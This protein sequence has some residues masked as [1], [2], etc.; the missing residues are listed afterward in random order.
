MGEKP[1]PIALSMSQDHSKL[2]E[3]LEKALKTREGIL[4]APFWAFREGLLRHIGIEETILLPS[5][6]NPSDEVKSLAQ[7]LRLEHGALTNLLVPEPTREI[8][9]ALQIILAP[10]NV[11]E[12]S[13]GGF[14]SFVDALPDTR[15]KD[16][17]RRIS[18]APYPP[19]R[20]YSKRPQALEAAKR[21]MQRAGYVRLSQFFGPRLT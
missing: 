9:K 20:P 13:A 19:L 11:R 14:Y 10:H 6:I 3:L 18:E 17:L 16:L 5:L 7:Q 1:G 2:D 21:A 15:V 8:V 4:S 12:E